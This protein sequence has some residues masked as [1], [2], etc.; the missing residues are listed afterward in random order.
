MKKH[1]FLFFFSLTSLVSFGQR[2]IG[3]ISG[4]GNSY[5]EEQA[6]DTATIGRSKAILKKKIT[7]YR[8]W[9]QAGD[10]LVLDTTLTIKTF[11]T[12]NF[13]MKDYFGNMP[14]SNIGQP[15]NPLTYRRNKSII[16]DIG[17]SAK[18]FNYWTPEDIRYF[19]VKSPLTEF[20]YIKGMEE[21]QGVST[22]FSYSPAKP[23]N[24]TFRYYGL[25]SRGRYNEQLASTQKFLVSSNFRSRNGR[26]FAIAHFNT[27]GIDNQESG[28]IANEEEFESGDPRFFNRKNVALNLSGVSTELDNRR[29]FLRHRYMLFQNPEDS[30]G[31][32]DGLSFS[33]QFSYEEKRYRYSEQNANSFYDELSDNFG[34]DRFSKTEY[35]FLSNEF[36][37][38]GQFLQEKGRFSAGV[39]FSELNYG[40]DTIINTMDVQALDKIEDDVVAL[41]I[42]SSV[43][44]SPSIAFLG[45]AQYVISGQEFKN[46]FKTKAQINVKPSKS[47]DIEAGFRESS[48][49]PTLN[50]WLYQSFYKRFTLNTKPKPINE[51]GLWGTLSHKK[52]GSIRLDWSTISNLA[53][54]DQNY[55]SV[56]SKSSI[57]IFKLSMRNDWLLFRRSIGKNPWELKLENAF[58]YQNIGD[59]ENALPLP[60]IITRNTLYAQGRMFKRNLHVQTGFTFHYFSR[61]LSRDFFPVFN[62]YRIQT[63]KEIGAFPRFDYFIHGKVDRFRFMLKAEHLN[64]NFTGFNY[65]SAPNYPYTDWIIRVGIIWFL[66]T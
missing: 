41:K 45:K 4:F 29:V 6:R 21:G 40:Y 35:A 5:R 14:F 54:I 51:R 48:T 42:E 33:H 8:Y 9:H 46:A 56:Q 60:D 50:Y 22:L 53:Y 37:V 11:H 20:R 58:I 16:P 55:Q 23:F 52:Y 62:E 63:D 44:I 43:T 66:N 17:F 36:W 1:V 49:F 39:V 19:D 28:G 18:Q 7:D 57:N 65:Y 64:S 61:F 26:Y 10:T 32:T 2:Q 25:R 27:Q 34:N 30:L 38:N 15:L 13:L 3:D 31:S 59:K 47:V 24:L 12:Q